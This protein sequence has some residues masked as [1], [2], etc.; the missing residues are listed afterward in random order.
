MIKQMDSENTLMLT[1]ANIQV[2]GSMMSKKAK[3]KKSGLMGQSIRANT[4]MER[5]MAMA[6]IC[7]AMEVN[8]QA[9]GRTTK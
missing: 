2:N 3:A 6:F 9:I 1:E 5:S 4:K 7:G 8:L